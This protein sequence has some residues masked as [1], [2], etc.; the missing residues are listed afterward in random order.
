MIRKFKNTE[1]RIVEC[2]LNTDQG[3]VKIKAYIREVLSD[4]VNV[5]FLDQTYTVKGY[6]VLTA[7]YIG[8]NGLKNIILT[9]EPTK[10]QDLK[11]INR[12]YVKKPILRK[13]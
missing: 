1:G 9:N 8:P 2:I 13:I 10:E 5:S 6:L 12:S 11:S 4:R 3:V 7:S